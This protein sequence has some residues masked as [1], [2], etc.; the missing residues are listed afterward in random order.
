MNRPDNQIEELGSIVLDEPI[1]N[2]IDPS[3]FSLELAYKLKLKSTNYNIKSIDEAEKNPKK[4]Q[5]WID[6]VSILHKE[7]VSSTV[8]YTKAMPNI[9][10]LM[11]IWPEK[12][13]ECLKEIILP[14]ENIDLK[15]ESYAGFVCNMLDIPVH[16]LNSNKSVIEALHVFFSLYSEFKDN[17]HFQMQN[18]KKGDE[19]IQTKKFY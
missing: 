17:Q 18:N 1:V 6:Q 7:K 10:N 3:I 5:T 15:L 9:E 11:Q 14:N 19:N 12:F 13:E 16:K 8:N 2:G 4:I